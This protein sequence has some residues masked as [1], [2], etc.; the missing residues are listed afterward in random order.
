MNKE[1]ESIGYVMLNRVRDRL[2][3]KNKNWMCVVCGQTGSGKSYAGLT[4]AQQIDPNFSADNIVF[5]P[6]EF[7]ALMNSGKLQKGSAIIFDEA[8]VG[9]G[10]REFASMSNRLMMF[11]AQT[12]RFKNYAVIFTVPAFSMI[13]AQARKLI[14]AYVETLSI[15]RRNKLCRTKFMNVQVNPRF[16]DKIYMKYPMIKHQDRTKKLFRIYFKLATEDLIEEYEEKRGIYI[17]KM[18]K[19]IQ[20]KLDRQYKKEVKETRNDVSET[21]KMIMEDKELRD[22]IIRE[23]KGGKSIAPAPLIKNYIPEITY[24]K[25]RA[26]SFILREKL[27]KKP[28]IYT[29]KP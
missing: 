1:K 21:V 11:V 19:E 9:I 14:H 6:S 28:Q 16:N 23:T 8:G 18:N 29:D 15:N 12:F 27:L 20:A 17:N 5:T 10:A 13:D 7:M 3:V 2:L 25:A 22:K 4:L 26:I 24:E